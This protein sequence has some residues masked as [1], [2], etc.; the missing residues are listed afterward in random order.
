MALVVLARF[1]YACLD[2]GVIIMT[3]VNN[4]LN[5]HKLSLSHCMTAHSITL[6]DLNLFYLAKAINATSVW[7][8]LSDINIF[9]PSLVTWSQKLA[10]YLLLLQSGHT[11]TIWAPSLRLV[12]P[13]LFRLSSVMILTKWSDNFCEK[14][15]FNSISFSFTPPSFPFLLKLI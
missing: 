1:C 12:V 8:T 4:H 2:L 9:Y 15:T 11:L 13:D 7:K 5:F 14:N 3:E 10:T 6:W